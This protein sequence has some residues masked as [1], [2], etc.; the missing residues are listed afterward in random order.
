MA[1]WA[2]LARLGRLDP[3]SLATPPARLT[4]LLRRVVDHLDLASTIRFVAPPPRRAPADAYASALLAL[5]D[6]SE[7]LAADGLLT[8]LGRVSERLDALAAA[9]GEPRPGDAP[10]ARVLEDA[11]VWR[12]SRLMADGELEEHAALATAHVV[13][14]GEGHLP[15]GYAASRAAAYLAQRAAAAPDYERATRYARLALEWFEPPFSL[16]LPGPIADCVSTLVNAGELE[17]AIRLGEPLLED[18]ELLDVLD[19]HRAYDSW[20]ATSMEVQVTLAL[21]WS[22]LGD[23]PAAIELAGHALWRCIHQFGDEAAITDSCRQMLAD[24][25]VGADR[26]EDALAMISPVYDRWIKTE[27]WRQAVIA[28]IILAVALSRTG[29]ADDASAVAQEI[30]DIAARRLSRDDTLFEAA[31]RTRARYAGT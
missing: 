20:V 7:D 8:G 9:A 15:V 14:A 19:H 31:Q 18:I 5:F 11:V 12:A 21:A 1:V 2:E 6:A 28:G 30:G 26:P 3:R 10:R 23:H 29:Q 25:L 24:F 17:S 27:A 4:T 13:L 22:R 16:Y